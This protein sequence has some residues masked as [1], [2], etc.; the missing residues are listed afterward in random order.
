M[1]KRLAWLLFIRRECKK[2][3]LD[4]F[5]CVSKCY[6]ILAKWDKEM[7]RKKL[8]QVSF[9][10]IIA[11]YQYHLET[12]EKKAKPKAEVGEVRPA[13]QRELLQDFK[14]LSTVVER[15]AGNELQR[16][17]TFRNAALLWKSRLARL[18]VL[19]I[20]YDIEQ[21]S[22]QK[23][24]IDWRE[25]HFVPLGFG[26]QVWS[27]NKSFQPT[28]D[29]GFLELRNSFNNIYSSED[30]SAY[31]DEKA[32][33]A[34]CETLARNAATREKS[35]ELLGILA[36]LYSKAFARPEGVNALFLQAVTTTFKLY[37]PGL[38]RKQIE[39]IN[40]VFVKFD[41]KD[42]ARK[43]II[44]VFDGLDIDTEIRDVIADA[45]YIVYVY[46]EDRAT[47]ANTF[48]TVS[49]AIAPQCARE[50][51]AIDA[52]AA[53]ERDLM[54]R[55]AE[56]RERET[57]LQLEHMRRE[58]EQ[59]E[60]E[61]EKL[62]EQRLALP[63]TVF[64]ERRD[65]AL[66]KKTFLDWKEGAVQQK[67]ERQLEEEK[68]RLEEERQRQQYEHAKREHQWLSKDYIDKARQPQMSAEPSVGQKISLELLVKLRGLFEAYKSGKCFLGSCFSGDKHKIQQYG[69]KKFEIPVEL[70]SVLSELYTPSIKPQQQLRL[71]V[72]AIQLSCVPYSTIAARRLS[73]E[74]QSVAM[75]CQ[76][77][78]ERDKVAEI[79]NDLIRDKYADLSDKS[80]LTAT[81]LVDLLMGLA[82]QE[83]GVIF[84]KP[85]GTHS[86]HFGK[87]SAFALE[88]KAPALAEMVV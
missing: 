27:C 86:D 47:I 36:E 10:E 48:S 16:G 43:T 54:E 56:K 78:F 66:L 31:F 87:I 59:R 39:A 38:E 12:D 15:V 44:T 75:V 35:I 11:V 84:D 40:E 28:Q 79:F 33:D 70:V 37:M 2:H 57:R 52:K 82:K 51:Q 23:L 50:Q 58:R 8:E 41:L 71:V 61:Q 21:F 29:I 65:A 3:D 46:A 7:S 42:D 45:F 24:L 20:Y 77:V 13:W 67:Q 64:S 63:L 68:R 5:V 4:L 18:I 76:L 80:C 26:E 55:L 22:H 73:A 34:I 53:E 30:I 69:D 81:G 88:G 32:I 25:K 85:R 72:N 17:L 19:Q 14:K 83:P 1:Q 6:S 49:A 9:E 74:L 62:A 60:L